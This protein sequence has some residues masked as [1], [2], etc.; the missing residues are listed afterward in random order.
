MASRS[1]SAVAALLSGI[2]PGLG[3]F[4]NRQWGKGAG[5]LAAIVVLFQLLGTAVNPGRPEHILEVGLPLEHLGLLMLIAV[6]ALTVAIW[7]IV[8]AARSA[9]RASPPV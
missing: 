4:Y 3:Q 5:F 8:D 2:L 9:R 1:Q 6:A 7:S